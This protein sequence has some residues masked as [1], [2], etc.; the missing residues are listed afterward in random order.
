M[1]LFYCSR[2][3][4]GVIDCG[5]RNAHGLIMEGACDRSVPVMGMETV[6]ALM[7]RRWNLSM[8]I[9]Q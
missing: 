1:G 6:G 5:S 2:P 4:G 8:M 3:W 9:M 7:E